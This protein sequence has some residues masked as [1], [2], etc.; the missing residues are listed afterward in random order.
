MQKLSP[1][2]KAHTAFTRH[3]V[4]NAGAALA[5]SATSATVACRVSLYELWRDAAETCV[6]HAASFLVVGV[7]GFA[8]VP[9]IS[10][11]LAVMTLPLTR[12][13]IMHIAVIKNLSARDLRQVP[14]LFATSWIYIA[15]PTIGQTALAVP[16]REWDII[17][18]FAEQRSAPWEGAAQTMMLRSLDALSLMSDSPL[19]HWLPAWRSQAHAELMQKPQAG[20]EQH[21][22][23]EY[24]LGVTGFNP[25]PIHAQARAFGLNSLQLGL[26]FVGGVLIVFG[27][28]TLFVFRSFLSEQPIQMFALGLRHFGIVASH[29][30]LL[31]LVN[32]GL[33]G[34]F[35]FAPLILVDRFS[36]LASRLNWF[37]SA[38][39][40]ASVS[41]CLALINAVFMIFEA[42]YAARLFITLSRNAEQLRD[43][44]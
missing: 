34:L 23:D 15:A 16:L 25:S 5:R 31:R 39:Q 19:K 41:I 42:V 21:L 29:L 32:V 44:W 4:S 24:G 2:P 1:L 28:E 40:I 38:P 14:A 27:A 33:K 6:A 35:V 43:G 37:G 10:P 3:V 30:W 7:I 9:L 20:Y 22:I 36:Y 11:A 26:L 18:D 17:L 13:V 12:A 8:L